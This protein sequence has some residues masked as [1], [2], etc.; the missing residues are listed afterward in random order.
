MK[1]VLIAKLRNNQLSQDH[2]IYSAQILTKG[3]LG[4]TDIID[5]LL[6][7]GMEQSRETILEIISHF[8]SKSAE[9]VA[10]GYNVNTGLVNMSPIIKGSLYRKKWN[11]YINSV[12]VNITDSSNLRMAVAEASVEM[13]GEQ[14]EPIDIYTITEQTNYS[15]DA[16]LS[17]ISTGELNAATKKS[18]EE[19]PACGIIFHNWL[20]NR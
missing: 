11:P 3:N 19:I 5:E 1:K 14:D 9:L 7:E 8:N 2:N 6:K 18:V 16:P 4:I 13:L 12:A 17:K 20:R 15:A 10:S